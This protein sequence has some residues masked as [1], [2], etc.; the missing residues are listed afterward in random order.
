MGSTSGTLNKL[1]ER[2]LEKALDIK[3]KRRK[4]KK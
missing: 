1:A 4:P 2:D 3:T